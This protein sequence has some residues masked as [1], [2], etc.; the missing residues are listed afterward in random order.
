VGTNGRRN[1]P[2][3]DEANEYQF[4]VRVPPRGAPRIILTRELDPM[5]SRGAREY[6]HVRFCD[7]P[8]R[9]RGYNDHLAAVLAYGAFGASGST[10]VT[11]QIGWNRY[12][13]KVYAKRVLTSFA[14]AVEGAACRWE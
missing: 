6:Q 3:Y 8:N 9:G 5:P 4:V 12:E 11:W 2:G 10:F 7:H 1:A 14:P 13:E